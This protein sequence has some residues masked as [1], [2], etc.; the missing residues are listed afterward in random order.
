LLLIAVTV[1]LGAVVAG[2]AFDLGSDSTNES[3][4]VSWNYEYDSRD[5][6]AELVSGDDLQKEALS[7][8][9]TCAVG[10]ISPSSTVTSGDTITIGSG[11][12]PGGETIRIIWTDPV[13]DNSAIVGEFSN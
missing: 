1:I 11:C 2:F 4:Q 8:E 13:S 12:D 9:G 6:V 5:V 7:V 3:P 10:S